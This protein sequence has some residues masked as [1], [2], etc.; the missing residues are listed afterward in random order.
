M[1]ALVAQELSG[2]AGLVYTDV[3]DPANPDQ[4]I[5]GNAM[6]R[7]NACVEYVLDAGLAYVS[8]PQWLAENVL[9]G[10]HVIAVAGTHGKTTTT[11]MIAHVLTHTGRR[12]GFLIGGIAQDLGVSAALGDADEVFVVEADEYDTAFFDKRSKFVHYRPRTLVLNNL[13]F[14]H[15][16]IFDDL[17][18]IQR[19]VHHLIRTVPAAGQLV[20]NAAE[21]A[22][23]DVLAQGCWTPVTEF[24]SV[25]GWHSE[26][27]SADGQRWTLV[28]G[29]QALGELE[30]RQRGAHNIANACAALAALDAV[31]VA[32]GEGMAALSIFRGVKR[33]LE[34]RG[35][36][37]GI[38]VFDDFAHHP[39]AVRGSLE[40]LRGRYPGRRLVAVFEPRTNTSRRR[41]FQQNY[42]DALKSADRVVVLRVPNTPIY[43]STG[44]VTELFSTD[45]LVEDLRQ[46]GVEATAHSR[47]EEIVA[48]LSLQLQTG[49]VVLVM[50]NGAF[51]DIWQKL[52]SS[53]AR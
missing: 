15:A 19:Q 32:P 18:A 4:V 26:Q 1:K 44:E 8:G 25:S 9:A 34:L 11:S 49:D 46:L 30:W 3:P 42:V 10:R 40:A 21:P 29:T 27:A 23:A 45:E 7:G 24:N 51:G 43:S 52:L 22:L 38:A 17:A 35:T 39:T 47:V 14:D 36:P 48:T 6:S 50:S 13:E 37:G 16:D 20:V 5:I 12:P 41:V 2:P 31:G 28:R 33:R 53:L